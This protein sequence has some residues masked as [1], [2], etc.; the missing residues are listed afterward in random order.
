[1]YGARL[2]ADLIARIDTWAEAQGISRSEAIRRLVEMAL[3]N[4]KRA[5]AEAMLD[6]A[7]DE[8]FPASDPV[9]LGHSDHVGRPEET[10]VKRGRK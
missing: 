1:M 10:P 3:E 9:E 2:S 5:G 8:S 4:G 7:L 6:E